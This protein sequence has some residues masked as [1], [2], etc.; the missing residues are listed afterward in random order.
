MTSEPMKIRKRLVIEVLLA[1][2]KLL[3]EDMD[4]SAALRQIGNSIHCALREMTE[5]KEEAK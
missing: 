5:R 2:A 3:A 1:I 4:T